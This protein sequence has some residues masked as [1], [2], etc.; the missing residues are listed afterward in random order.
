[1]QAQADHVHRHQ[2][3]EARPRHRADQAQL[4][5]V[6]H[7]EQAGGVA[8]VQVLGHQAGGVLHRHAVAGKGHHAGAQFQVQ[9][10][11]RGG[12]QRGRPFGHG[13]RGEA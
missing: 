4:A 12:Q 7:V 5:H 10:V 2:A 9:R 11:E 3:F 6:R 13:A 1:V 8:G